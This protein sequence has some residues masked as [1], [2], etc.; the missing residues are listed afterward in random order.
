MS[1]RIINIG[2]F[3]LVKPKGTFM[4]SV[5]PKLS[6]GFIRNGH[7]VFDFSDRDMAMYFAPFSAR[8]LG[9]PKANRLLRRLCAEIVPDLLVLG[10]ADII[11]PETIAAIRRDH[12]HVRVLQWNV[13]PMFEPDNVA[14]ICRKLDV[15]DATLVSTAGEALRPLARPGKLLGFFPNPVDFSIE[16]GAA[17]TRLDLPFDLFCGAGSPSGTRIIGGETISVDAL[18]TRIQQEIPGI[19]CKLGMV[20]N[21]PFLQGY[22]YQSALSQ[23]AIGI[24]ISRRSDAFLYS[25]DRLAHMV[26]NGI[27]TLIDRRTGYDQLF[28]EDALVFYNDISE[29]IGHVRALIADPARR[30][31]IAAKGRARYHQLFNEQ[32]IARYVVDA[33]FG[34]V[35][36][37]DYEW[38]SLVNF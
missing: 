27:A 19:R 13:D 8:Q 25:S 2:H 24:N 4:H 28:A 34:T 23:S 22:P 16:S 29:M 32:I 36:P 14:R 18:V 17:H 33:A 26:G 9:V 35:R 15:V 1:L 10:H 11:H 21:N 6:N 31:A 20:L 3:N 37:E 38:P 5:A 12:P 7:R 30:A